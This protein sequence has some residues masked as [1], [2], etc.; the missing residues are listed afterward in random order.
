MPVSLIPLASAVTGTL[1]DSSAP[2]GSVIQVVQATTT[3][4]T[5][6][7]VGNTNTDTALT[8]S[9]TPTSSS[10]KVLVIISLPFILS[11]ST[12]VGYCGFGLKRN[13]TVIYTPP[14]D[15]TGSFT[16]G[17]QVG[18]S[19]SIQFDAV[20]NLQFLDSPSST[21]AVSYTVFANVYA[22]TGQ[23]LRVPYNAGGSAIQ[24]GVITLMEIAA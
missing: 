2:S 18:N 16:Y 4:M 8:G 20:C 10:S 5:T 19:T 15:G 17:M 1:P 24:T 22:A 21:S 6:I 14:N 11:A 9:I 13:S 7:A 12:S 3:T 23:A